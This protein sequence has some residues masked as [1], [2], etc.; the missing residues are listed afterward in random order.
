M[1]AA[2]FKY[3]GRPAPRASPN[4]RVVASRAVA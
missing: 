4:L 3:S 1:K 2:K